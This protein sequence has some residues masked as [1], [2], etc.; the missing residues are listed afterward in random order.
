MVTREDIETLYCK[1]GMTNGGGILGGSIGSL[2]VKKTKLIL[3]NKTNA[4]DSSYLTSLLIN[5][6]LKKFNTVRAEITNIHNSRCT[7]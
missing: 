1:P 5:I 4:D 3:V 7:N 6:L 2:N